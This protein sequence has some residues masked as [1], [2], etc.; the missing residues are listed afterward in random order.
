M[1]NKF[2]RQ[3]DGRLLQKNFKNL[4]DTYVRKRREYEDVLRK[5]SGIESG[6]REKIASWPFFVQL[7]FID[8][9]DDNDGFVTI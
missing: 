2:G 4:R 3:Y 7:R 1:S 8:P 6:L 5:K 9:P